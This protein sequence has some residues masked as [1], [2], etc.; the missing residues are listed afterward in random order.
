MASP[1]STLSCI[2]QRPISAVRRGR[3]AARFSSRGRELISQHKGT[4]QRQPAPRPGTCGTACFKPC[5]VCEP[6]NGIIWEAALMKGLSADSG[7]C[8]PRTGHRSCCGLGGGFG[9]GDPSTRVGLAGALPAAGLW[10]VPLWLCWHPSPDLKYGRFGVIWGSG[11]DVASHE[12]R[13]A[14][15]SEAWARS[16][17][18]RL[19]LGAGWGHRGELGEN[20]SC[21]LLCP[22]LGGN[23]GQSV[24]GA[25]AW[26]SGGYLSLPL[27]R[28]D[29]CRWRIAVFEFLR[30]AL[31]PQS[32]FLSLIKRF[33]AWRGT[34][35]LQSQE[36]G[37]AERGTGSKTL[38]LRAAQ[39]PSLLLPCPSPGSPALPVALQ[40]QV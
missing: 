14:A 6:L 20:S 29:A 7:R 21:V 30:A 17:P 36:R 25:R 2:E 38:T 18:A 39:S 31:L 3:G 8:S 16:R 5:C 11:G 26:G 13:R 24:R 15:Q 22:G 35:R 37:P 27:Q 28:R 9:D 40:P 32:L 12:R 33:R 1:S 4:S 34:R 19:S 10:R 23:K